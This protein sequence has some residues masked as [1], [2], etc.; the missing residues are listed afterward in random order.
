MF[1]FIFYSIVFYLMIHNAI[2]N[3]RLDFLMTMMM[4]CLFTHNKYVTV[5]WKQ[6]ENPYQGTNTVL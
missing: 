3:K 5:G 6:F 2:S 4:F 1:S